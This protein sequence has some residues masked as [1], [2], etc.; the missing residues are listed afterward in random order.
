MARPDRPPPQ[1]VPDRDEDGNTPVER[2]LGIGEALRDVYRDVVLEDL[3][4]EI[5]ELL[6]RL[7]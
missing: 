5:R 3:P 4:P 2:A 6:R 1:S 7:A